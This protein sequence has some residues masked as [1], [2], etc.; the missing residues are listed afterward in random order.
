MEHKSLLA[1]D[2]A[3]GYERQMCNLKNNDVVRTHVHCLVSAAKSGDQ[4]D[5]EDD[6][7]DSNTDDDPNLLL[8]WKKQHFQK[9]FMLY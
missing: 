3:E 8:R 7:E 2:D 6:E 5:G 9:F 1:G 4:Y